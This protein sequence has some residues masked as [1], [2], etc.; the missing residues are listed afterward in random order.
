MRIIG[1]LLFACSQKDSECGKV[2]TLGCKILVN[3]LCLAI[4]VD[5]SHLVLKAN[6]CTLVADVED[7]QSRLWSYRWQFRAG[8]GSDVVDGIE[9][10]YLA[11]IPSAPVE[12]LGAIGRERAS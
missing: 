11:V 4:L 2:N 3:I 9:L 6:H 12:Y 7:I 10:R 1:H 8:F 5:I